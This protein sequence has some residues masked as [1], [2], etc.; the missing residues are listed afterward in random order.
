[1][2]RRR[3]K[4]ATPATPAEPVET[5]PP[6]PR[7][8]GPWDASEKSSDDEPAYLDFGS[9]KVLGRAGFTFQM[10][11]SPT[12]ENAPALVLVADGAALELRLFA[13]SRSGSLWDE[14][15][16]DLIADIQRHEGE[17]REEDGR[18]GTELMA[19]LPATLPDGSEGF[20]PSRIVGIDGPRWMLRATFLG[21]AA[22]TSS[23][24]DL[25]AQALRDVIVV[26][27]GEPRIPREPLLLTVPEGAR[28]IKT[29]QDRP[30]EHTHDHGE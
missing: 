28:A 1:M 29:S 7:H 13:A 18:Y 24:D 15:R 25:L 27:G 9:L 2:I 21:T 22:L 23:D 26:R 4:D 20:Q 12:G 14:V 10:P 8:E 6:G 19:R 16:P 11:G 3:T 17:F 5:A 30:A